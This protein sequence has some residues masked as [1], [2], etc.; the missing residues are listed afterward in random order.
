MK[1]GFIGLG[2]IGAPMAERVLAAGFDLGVWNRS[3]DKT[4]DLVKRGAHLASSPAAL[5]DVCE[6][7]CI[8]VTDGA[9]LDQIIFGASGVTHAQH[10]PQYIVDHST[11][12]PDQTCEMAKRLRDTTGSIWIDAPISGGRIGAING[13]LATF[14]GGPDAG[15]EAVTPVLNS[16]SS[17]VTHMGPT[18]SGQATKA[19]NQLIGFLS[20]VALSEAL[21]LAENLGLD[22]TKLP[23]ALQGGFADTPVLQEWNRT[24]GT[25][26]LIGLPLHVEAL[27]T[28]L[29]GQTPLPTYQGPSPANLR[30]DIA[31]IQSLA[32]QTDTPLPLTDQ[33]AV[34]VGLL[35]AS[36]SAIKDTAQ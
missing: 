6:T 26:P 14:V 12:P 7:L 22:T 28:L 36:H 34:V 21:V 23:A 33:M 2:V 13:T 25:D 27:R 17:A 19:C 24:R 15:V 1:T 20:A 29:S 31:I 18:G 5:A 3:V 9:A 11:V 16:F 10:P 8:C 35:H 30:K 32:R 4:V